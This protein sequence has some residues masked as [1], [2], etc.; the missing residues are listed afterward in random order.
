MLQ[1]EGATEEEVK[2]I[3]TEVGAKYGLY[4]EKYVMLFK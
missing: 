3:E 4:K 1:E 2:V